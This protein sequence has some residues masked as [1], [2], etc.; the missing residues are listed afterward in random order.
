MKNVFLIGLLACL[1]TAHSQDSLVQKEMEQVVVTATK[2]P[3]KTSQTG[4]VITIITRQQLDAAGSKD[5]GQVLN[6]QTGLYVNGSLSGPGKDQSIYLRGARIDHTLITIDG[7][8]VYDASGIGGNF[9][10]RNLSTEQVERIEILKG[11]Q[12]TLYGSDAIAGVINIITRKAPTKGLVQEVSSSYGSYG[13]YK[14][15]LNLSGKKDWFDFQVSYGMLQSKGIDQVIHAPTD[16]ERDGYNQKSLQASM[17]YQ[18]SKN[19]KIKP[20][21]RMGWLSGDLDQGAFTEELDYTYQQKSLQTGFSN[22]WQLKQ[23]QLNL[24]YNFN[25]IDRNYVDDSVKSRNGYA[26]YSRGE[27]KGGEHMVDF[28]LG[29]FPLA[30]NLKLTG[31]VDFRQSGSDQ[32]FLSVSSY[33]P[34]EETYHKDRLHQQQTGLYAAVNWTTQAGFNLEAGSRWNHHSA[35]GSNQVFNINPSFLWNEQLKIFFNLSSAYRTPSLYQLFSEFGNARLKPEQALNSEA[36]VQY[37]NSHQ[38]LTFRGTFFHRKTKN[39]HFFYTDPTTYASTYINQDLQMEKGYEMELSFKFSKVVQLKA[40]YTHV[41]GKVTTQL[42][43]KDST[44][45]SLLRRPENLA[46]IALQGAFNKQWQWNASAQ[47]LSQRMDAY[48]NS[49]LYSTVYNNLP[50]FTVVNILLQ[51]SKPNSPFSCFGQVNNLFNENVVEIS[52]YAGM[53]RNG[54]LGIRF[55]W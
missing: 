39:L 19:W 38:K 43:G 9:D 24:I 31:G 54:S 16:T 7:I 45:N 14:N 41:S 10:I 20:Y 50:A 11:A 8:P 21:V 44:Y 46:S 35:Y 34:Y 5:L 13:T 4:K 1:S 40:S 51:Y 55:K 6:E 12:S 23:G 49:Q 17:G 53:G 30:K 47:Y 33:G 25:K 26:D 36:G 37:Q 2:Y 52:G 27:Y 29:A 3:L 28:Y 18:V 32:S 22:L 42:N 15:A 48:Y